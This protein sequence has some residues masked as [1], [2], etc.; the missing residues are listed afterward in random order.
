MIGTIGV[1]TKTGRAVLTSSNPFA[2]AGNI[3][4]KVGP[5]HFVVIDGSVTTCELPRPKW[6]FN[7]HKVVV[8]IGANAHMY[9]SG[10]RIRDIPVFYFPYAAF[11]GNGLRGNRD[12]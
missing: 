10:F 2:F 9:R 7:A 12:F 5:D 8:D 3:V 1:Q 11:P 6:T 4:E